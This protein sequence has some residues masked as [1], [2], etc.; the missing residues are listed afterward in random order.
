MLFHKG[1]ISSSRRRRLRPVRRGAIV[2]AMEPRHLLSAVVSSGSNF[3]VTTRVTF[4]SGTNVLSSGVS[5]SPVVDSAGDLFGFD[6]DGG[7]GS[8]IYEIP[9]NS[10]QIIQVAPFGNVTF[11]GTDEFTSASPFG[12]LCVDSHDNLYALSVNTNSSTVSTVYKLNAGSSQL[13]VITTFVAPVPQGSIICD[14]QGDVFFFGADQANSGIYEIPIGDNAPVLLA[15]LAIQSPYTDIDLTRDSKNDLFGVD[16]NS[17]FELPAGANSVQTLANPLIFDEFEPDLTVDAMGNLFGETSTGGVFELPAGAT[18]PISLASPSTLAGVGGLTLD[19]AGDLFGITQTGSEGDLDSGGVFEIDGDTHAVAR[20]YSFP[21]VTTLALPTFPDP[22]ATSKLPKPTGSMLIDPQGNLFFTYDDAVDQITY[23]P[24]VPSQ[25]VFQ[26]QPVNTTIGGTLPDIV[27]AI[28]DQNGL[29]VTKDTSAITLTLESFG[30]VSNVSNQLLG[31][32]TAIPV[33]GIVTFTGLS[34]SE[35]GSFTLYAVSAGL[36]RSL[37]ESS[38]AFGVS[39]P[40]VNTTTTLQSTLAPGTTGQTVS[41][42]ATVSDAELQDYSSE[43]VSF[44]DGGNLIGQAT[45]YRFVPPSDQGSS[46][47]GD[48]GSETVGSS[49]AQTGS[50]ATTQFVATLKL[51]TITAGPHAFTA[52]YGGDNLA[53][54]STSNVLTVTV[55]PT[56]LV[57][58]L[59]SSALPAIVISGTR[60]NATVVATLTNQSTTL[61]KGPTTIELFAAQTLL[62]KVTRSIKIKPGKTLT[63]PMHIGAMPQLP[64]AGTYQLQVEAMDTA[65]TQSISATGPAFKYAIAFAS[66]SATFKTLKLPKYPLVAGVKSTVSTQLTVMNDGNV[67]WNAPTTLYLYVADSLGDIPILFRTLTRHLSIRTSASVQLVIPR[68]VLPALGEGNYSIEVTVGPLSNFSEPASE[69]LL[70]VQPLISLFPTIE[71]STPAIARIGSYVTMTIRIENGGNTM[72]DGSFPIEIG[73]SPDQFHFPSKLLTIGYDLKIPVGKT[74]RVRLRFKV[75]K[76]A[77]VGDYLAVLLTDPDNG[78]SEFSVSK[79]A[80]VTD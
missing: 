73:V 28:E 24:S 72:A 30:G 15:P 1:H 10:K 64:N 31:T 46:G 11:P 22:F 48:S 65:G 17:I 78:F 71:K 21:A 47:S 54:P 40:K 37:A 63:I 20:I 67:N 26:E 52:T 18:Q 58:N 13:N 19:S 23:Y 35:A 50:V 6:S 55:P 51:A 62:L 41:L 57:P 4:G 70:V 75:P 68:A 42:T 76:Q 12:P 44:F 39:E 66:L 59:K 7:F 80:I 77:A 9:V 34:V 32:A 74:I 43:S 8:E 25:L 2:E 56:N 3:V 49:A 61:Q 38:V 33:D 14:P 53:N 60:V 79:T 36:N 69:S 45:L 29:V 5:G 16:G 27:V